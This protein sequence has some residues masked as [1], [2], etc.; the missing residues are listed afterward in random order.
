MS[1]LPCLL[2]LSNLKILAVGAGKTGKR[3]VKTLLSNG[4]SNLL[5][6]DPAI[7]NSGVL[8]FLEQL[9]SQQQQD[10]SDSVVFE[11]RSLVL[12]DLVGHNIVFACTDSKDINDIISHECKSHNILCNNVTS[13]EK[14]S[15][16]L[17]AVGSCEGLSI[18]VSTNGASPALAAHI[19]TVIV[20]DVLPQY[21]IFNKFLAAIRTPILQLDLDPSKNAMIFKQLV[22]SPICVLINEDKV[23][24]VH[25]ALHNILPREIYP[26][27]IQ[28]INEL[29]QK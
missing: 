15:F 11:H 3:K 10:F 22:A 9:S 27:A 29:M 5:W 28:L 18:S 26:I 20:T 19:R 24:K 21:V 14:S 1:D 17:P 12:S 25:S 13:P 6:L 23:D 8:L 2:N 7:T 4:A 16:T